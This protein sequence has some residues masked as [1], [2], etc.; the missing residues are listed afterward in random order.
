MLGL[1]KRDARSGSSRP[2]WQV[3]PLTSRL[4]RPT[5]HGWRPAREERARGVPRPRSVSAVSSRR[6]RPTTST[7]SCTGSFR[8]V[9]VAGAAEDAELVALKAELDARAHRDAL[10]ERTGQE[11]LLR[12]RERALR[13]QLEGADLARTTEL[14][15]HLVRVHQALTEL[16]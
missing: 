5:R 12:L 1:P 14:Q 3:G 6:S 9:L 4:E 15:A 13:R 8:A 10:D 2:R 16:R 7:R 11:L